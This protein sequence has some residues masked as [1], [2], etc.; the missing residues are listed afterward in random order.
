M[1]PAAK[2][3]VLRGHPPNRPRLTALLMIVMAIV[4]ITPASADP[5]PAQGMFLVANPEMRGTWFAESV[6]LLIQHDEHGTIGLIINRSTGMPPADMLPDIAELN[7]LQGNLYIGGPVASYGITMLVRSDAPPNEAKHVFANVYASGSRGLLRDIA[8]DQAS[9][10]R[11]RLYAG[12]AG[13][14]PGQLDAEIRRGSW[15]VIPAAEELVFSGDPAE[16]W[17]SLE[18]RTRTIIVRLNNDDTRL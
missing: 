5:A 17:E 14:G 2:T 6:I 12:H 10:E 1:I 13:W 7:Q 3:A 18:T 9:G 16:I 15:T 11:L 4:M 8:G